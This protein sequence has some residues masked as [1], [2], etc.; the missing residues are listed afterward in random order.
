MNIKLEM[1]N[2]SKYTSTYK[3]YT[4]TVH[5]HAHNILY[6]GFFRRGKYFHKFSISVAICERFL[7]ENIFSSKLDTVLVGVVH[8]VTIRYRPSG[9]GALGYPLDTML[10]GVVHWVT[11]RYRASGRGALGYH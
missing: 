7:H 10:V 2:T 5:H 4:C 3:L 8:W 6:S 9:C 1:D 11:I